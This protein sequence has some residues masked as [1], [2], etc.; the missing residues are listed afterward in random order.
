M[1]PVSM[2]ALHRSQGAKLQRF[3]LRLLGNSADAAD[4]HQET[5]LRMLAALSRTSVE[6]PSAFPVPRSRTTSPC[7]CGTGSGWKGRCSI[8]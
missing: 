3:L 8:P 6:N 5:Y 4:A 1:Q 2:D 7:G